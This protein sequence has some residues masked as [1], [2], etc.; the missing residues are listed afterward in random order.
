MDYSE[1]DLL[2]LSGI[3]HFAYC[4]RQWALIHVENQWLENIG[5][6]QGRL[7]HQRVDDPFYSESRGQL[8]IERSLPLVSRTLGLYGVADLMEIEERSRGE[9]VTYNLVE[10]KR[11]KPKVDARDQVQLCAQAICVEEMRNIR[12]N[13]G[14]FY[15]DMVKHRQRVEFTVQL[16]ER[17]KKLAEKMHYYYEN[18]ITPLVKKS[19]KC[20]YCSLSDIC[21]PKL[22][23]L[24]GRSSGY[25]ANYLADLSVEE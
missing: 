5:T 10:Y 18:G 1:E 9:V 22:E 17:V 25:L 7:I 6:A 8:K 14:Y 19:S 13:Y 3:Q 21:V 2:P 11:G 12:L 15:Y 20:R 16:R 24:R 4:P 23:K